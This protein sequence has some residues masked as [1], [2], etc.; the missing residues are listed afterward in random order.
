MTDNLINGKEKQSYI[1]KGMDCRS[2]KTKIESAVSKIDGVINSNLN[3]ISEKLLVEVDA[4]RAGAISNNIID[5]IKKLGYAIVNNDKNNIAK[6]KWWQSRDAKFTIISILLLAIAT[7]IGF[8][9]PQ[10][11]DVLFSAVALFA[12]IPLA[13]KMFSNLSTGNYFSIELLV[14][15]AV[16]GA[17]FIDE[18]AE[19]SIVVILFL[20]GEL[21]ENIAAE[22][23]RE[24]V[25]ALAKL[26]PDTAFLVDGDKIVEVVANE[27]KIG[28]IIEVRAGGRIPADG[29]IIEGTTNIDESTMTGESIPVSKKIEDSVFAGSLNIDGTIRVKVTTESGSNTIAKIIH[30]VEEAENSKAPT[31]RFIDKFSKYYTPFIILISIL[32]SI[33]P[34]L[35]FAA[36]FGDW[37]YKGLAILLIGCP[38]AL[39]LSVP[40]AVTSG[41]ASG[42]KQ[43]LLIKGGAI[44][45]KIGYLR[46]FAFDKTGTLTE[47]V[48]K[49]TDIISF[50][51]RSAENKIL[52]L[53]A[54]VEAS[55]LHPLAV[56]I[57]NRA[58]ELKL[59]INKVENAKA[60]H[61][62]GV[63]ATLEEGE[64]IVASPIYA[65]EITNITDEQNSKISKLEHRGKTVVVVIINNVA[66][67]AIA[68]R[69]ELRTDAGQ[70]MAE[71]KNLD[72]E[73]VML[74]GDNIRTGTA[75]ADRLGIQVLAELMPSAKVKNI[76]KLKDKYKTGVAMVG[77]GINDAPA[78][79]SADVGIA[80]GGG[81]DVALETADAAI[82]GEN[83]SSI[84]ALVR[85]S[86]AT[87]TNI[88]QN[89][90]VALGLKL[91]FLITT[92]L[93]M[94]NL[95]MA[96][97][98]D[99]GATVIVTLNA[100]RLLRFNPR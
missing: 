5:V 31:A 15:I 21:L 56:A 72:I 40:A 34:P 33:V 68:M 93:G 74:T 23:A 2:C 80:M 59:K 48:P 27:L 90:T 60:I 70:A 36:D 52:S 16:I 32:I 30:L 19:A 51:R 20:I 61:G 28:Q 85:L 38:C 76:H 81:T 11:R 25:R 35:F 88:K 46:A 44:L 13:K 3:Y 99:T 64:V 94:T 95:W 14:V 54:A 24:G 26:V 57:N 96:I 42:A 6:F 89:I 63:K 50:D 53:A 91:V 65:K 8:L 39:V 66:I 73:A 17:I 86:R 82:L 9:N 43:G 67:G 83:I 12:F 7:I 10:L 58:K 69:D 77:D 78:L 79:A 97:L 47:G 41:I 87:I 92:L 18:S 1:I 100:L 55:S 49:V 71:L 45:E 37:I 84:P 4:K 22:K 29:I 98:A 62:K 75:L